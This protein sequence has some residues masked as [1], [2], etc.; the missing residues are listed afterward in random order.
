MAGRGSSVGIATLYGAGRIGDR[1]P[2]GGGWG[3]SAS[4]QTGP[5]PH[6]ASYTMVTGSLSPGIKRPGRGVDHLPSSSAEVKET[7]ELY[8]SW[9]VPG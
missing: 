3:Y 4:V 1:N 5:G 2:V 7:V 6:Q 9:P 8:V